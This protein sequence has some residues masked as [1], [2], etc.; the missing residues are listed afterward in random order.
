MNKVI[1]GFFATTAFAFGMFL[2]LGSSGCGTAP[3]NDSSQ[4]L[5]TPSF[6]QGDPEPSPSPSP[7]GEPPIASILHHHCPG[8]NNEAFFGLSD[9]QILEYHYFRRNGQGS[10]FRFLELGDHDVGQHCP[11]TITSDGVCVTISWSDLSY[12]WMYDTGWVKVE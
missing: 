9:G 4:P 11:F 5:E 10:L 8:F 6:V 12:H 7:R 3:V 1:Y 2:I